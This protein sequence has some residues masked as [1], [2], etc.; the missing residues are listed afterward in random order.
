[1]NA[2]D[3]AGQPSLSVYLDFI[4]SM[5]ASTMNIDIIVAS[6]YRYETINDIFGFGII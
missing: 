6:L 3:A 1:M 5:Q 2:T 4:A